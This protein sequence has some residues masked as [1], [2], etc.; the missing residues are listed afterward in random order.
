MPDDAPLNHAARNTLLDLLSEFG[1]IGV[2]QSGGISRLAASPEDGLA[3]DFL[4]DWLKRHDFE[5]LVDEIGN[6]FGVLDLTRGD[7]ARHFF[8]GSH[9]DSQPDGGKFDG[10]LGVVCACVCGLEIWDA[11][12][13]GRVDPSYRFYVVACWTGEEGARF[14]PSLIGSS[15]FDGSVPL[16][17]ALARQDQYGVSLR[18]ALSRIG[19]LGN[20]KVPAP[21]H[22][23]EIH[24]EQGAKLQNANKPVGIVSSCWGAKKMRVEV[25]GRPDHTGPTPMEDRRDAL[26]AASHLVVQANEVSRQSSSTLY[27]SVGRIEVSPNSPNTIADK[28]QL[29]V[30]FRSNDGE[31]LL[32]AERQ[33][34]RSFARIAAS[35]GCELK[36]ASAEDRAVVEFDRQ[37]IAIVEDIL[38]KSNIPYLHM[39][40]IAGH[41]A[42]RLQSVC[43]STLLFVP[44]ENG[45][46][47]SPEEFTSDEDICAGF[48]AMLHAVSS[49]IS[50]S[51]SDDLQSTSGEAKN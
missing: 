14:Q 41:D 7:P 16:E 11:V 10:V 6:I 32:E 35:T 24:I 29:W 31:A 20:A 39:S 3:R 38:S 1:K 17:H 8:C 27:S 49:L 48:D 33:F 22:Y 4:C 51:A 46:S 13:K 5:I 19:Y 25:S 43:P 45:I 36:V 44:S 40:T 18:E 42:I 34:E 50:A 21:G 37:S 2:T 23:L 26:L 47:H 9:L 28:V 15:V 30:E 12:A